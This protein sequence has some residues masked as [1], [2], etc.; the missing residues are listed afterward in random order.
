[1]SSMSRT[2]KRRERLSTS[3]TPDGP[4]VSSA[5]HPSLPPRLLIKVDGELT[6]RPPTSVYL[7]SISPRRP[8][9]LYDLFTTSTMKFFAPFF[10]LAAALAASAATVDPA[11]I[12]PNSTY[13]WTSGSTGTVSWCVPSVAAGGRRG[14][15]ICFC[16]GPSLT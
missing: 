7:R 15:L 13:V 3:R 14:L 10:A 4:S 16:A 12:Y 5:T 1:M 9:R 6:C 8:H 2:Q 11:I